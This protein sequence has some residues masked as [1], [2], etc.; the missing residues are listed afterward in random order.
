MGN[1]Q[2]ALNFL[3]EHPRYDSVAPYDPETGEAGVSIGNPTREEWDFMD[4]GTM[5]LV[6]DD[7][8]K[9]E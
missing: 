2:E 7:L 1:I 4:S 8:S 6:D 3:V 5:G 9:R